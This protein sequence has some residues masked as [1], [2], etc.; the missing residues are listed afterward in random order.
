MQDVKQYPGRDSSK[1][2]KRSLASNAPGGR[3]EGK[4]T[5][6]KATKTY[7]YQDNT[8]LSRQDLNKENNS[9]K[10]TPPNF[11]RKQS[12]EPAS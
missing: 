12:R 5:T 7:H 4:I 8:I 9:D 10:Q 11:L 3:G 6:M 1:T 2:L